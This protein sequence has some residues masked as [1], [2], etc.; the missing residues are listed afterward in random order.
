[1]DDYVQAGNDLQRRSKI[2]E[3]MLENQRL[4]QEAAQF[5]DSLPFAKNLGLSWKGIATNYLYAIEG[6]MGLWVRYNGP[7][8]YCSDKARKEL[9]ELTMQGECVL[10]CCDGFHS[11]SSNTK[12]HHYFLRC[13]EAEENLRSGVEF[14][15]QSCDNRDQDNDVSKTLIQLRKIDI[16]A[17][18]RKD[19]TSST[20]SKLG[21][22]PY[23]PGLEPIFRQNYQRRATVEINP[24]AE[25][26]LD[27]SYRF[28][29]NM[30]QVIQI[31]EASEAQ[32]HI[33]IEVQRIQ[34]V[35]NIEVEFQIHD[36]ANCGCPDCISH[37]VTQEL[38]EQVNGLLESVGISAPS[39]TDGEGQQEQGLP[40]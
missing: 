10:A 26:S 2:V 25:I 17:E 24:C 18:E 23:T 12:E 7:D 27:E 1:M 32:Q 14:S 6:H 11:W 20:R 9:I 5:N 22:P 31:N 36:R 34:P 4:M 8:L 21:F 15:S 33:R 30:D 38:Q 35:N 28:I 3:A 19:N 39:L 13:K 29:Q 37:R 16:E 40:F